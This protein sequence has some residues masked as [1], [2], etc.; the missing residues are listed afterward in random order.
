MNKTKLRQPKPKKAK[1][2]EPAQH[3]LPTSKK[4]YATDAEKVSAEREHMTSM[5]AASQWGTATDVQSAANSWDATTTALD[6]NATSIEKMRSDLAAAIIIQQGLRLKW[7]AG[8]RHTLSAVSVFAGGD[9][10]IITAFGFDLQT[11]AAA[12]AEITV[13][14]GIVT[15]PGTNLGDIDVGW[16]EGNNRHGFMLQHCTNPADPS[17]F[18]TPIPCTSPDFILT[19]QA[20]GAVIHF[21]VASI[22]PSLP[23]HMTAYSAWVAG[24]AH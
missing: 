17:T 16:D 9:P 12:G 4:P 24:T 5:K 13:P 10:A 11:K 2:K 6:S 7:H 1:P 18:S 8:R 20:S 23:G 3:A 19:G 21:R 15:S 14:E 22:D